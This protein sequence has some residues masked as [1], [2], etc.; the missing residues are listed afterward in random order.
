MS[1]TKMLN[2][3]D[4]AIDLWRSGVKTVDAR[5]LVQNYI[6]V[7]SDHL[8]I[9]NQRF[10]LVDFDRIRVVGAGKVV[11]VMG[12][13]LEDALGPDLMISKN[14]SGLVNV[15]YGKYGGRISTGSRVWQFP[16]RPAGENLPTAA[17]F[18]ATLLIEDLVQ[19]A[20][21]RELCICL[22]SGGASALMTH[23]P[24]KIK[25]HDKRKLI[26]WLSRSGASIQQVNTIRQ[27]VSD[28]KGGQLASRFKGFH[29]V[30]LL[31]SDVIG[32]QGELIGSGP[33]YRATST[34]EDALAVLAQIDPKMH[35]TP[36]SI[37]RHLKRAKLPTVKVPDNVSNHIIGHIGQAIENAVEFGESQG[38]NCTSELQTDELETVETAGGR[39][40][41]WILDQM[42]RPSKKPQAIVSGGEPVIELCTNPGTGGRNSQLVLTA[43][44]HILESDVE[45]NQPFALLAGGT[46]G[47]D[48]NAPA[49]GAWISNQSLTRVRQM[50]LN[51]V[52]FLRSNNS[53]QFFARLG[54]GIFH[55]L[56]QYQ[57][58]VSDLR[59]GYVGK[60]HSNGPHPK[61]RL[62]EQSP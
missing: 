22:L 17:A 50:E 7:D 59:I 25:L 6:H 55:G 27:H 45:I 9:G 23:P 20:G 41:Q 53:H 1:N 29:M 26:Q 15:P 31:I 42:T 38:F 34:P 24:K 12:E 13:A 56:P 8:V 40:G 52:G 16:A 28:V 43:L 36:V 39:L 3:V 60:K 35:N 18:G 19:R 58:N 37:Q 51:P 33:T 61:I 5:H 54:C 4:L 21:S 47:E 11:G 57:T 30:C 10:P 62:Q 14:V 46:D 44:N 48:G 2:P 49:A 32:N